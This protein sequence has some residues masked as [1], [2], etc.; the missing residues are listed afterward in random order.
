MNEFGEYYSIEDE[1]FSSKL[2]KVIT[3]HRDL[4]ETPF[5][6]LMKTEDTEEYSGLLSKFI[7]RSRDDLGQQQ[8]NKS[9][10]YIYGLMVVAN[11][12][13]HNPKNYLRDIDAGMGRIDHT[14][15]YDH[16]NGFKGDPWDYEDFTKWVNP[17]NMFEEWRF[18]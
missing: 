15:N 6:Y 13:D 9:K 2:L 1:F 11:E 7:L 12:A 14:S 17:K 16:L 5:V 3:S 18:M 4:V 8:N 10:A